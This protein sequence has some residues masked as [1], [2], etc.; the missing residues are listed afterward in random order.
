MGTGEFYYLCMVIGAMAVF[1]S[2]AGDGRMVQQPSAAA[3]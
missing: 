3:E 1:A 2:H